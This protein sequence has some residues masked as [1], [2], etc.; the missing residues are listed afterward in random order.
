MEVYEGINSYFVTCKLHVDH[1]VKFEFIAQKKS[2]SWDWTW[3][4]FVYELCV[5]ILVVICK[6]IC[7]RHWMFASIIVM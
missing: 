4:T 6:S 3:D 5:V 1:T 2:S 7:V